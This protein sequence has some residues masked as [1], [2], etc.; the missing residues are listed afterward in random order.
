MLLASTEN[1]AAVDKAFE[2]LKKLIAEREV[3]S[4]WAYISGKLI[5]ESVIDLN[6]DTSIYNF[7]SVVLSYASDMIIGGDDAGAFDFMDDVITGLKKI[8]GDERPEGD[9]IDDFGGG[10]LKYAA[11]SRLIYKAVLREIHKLTR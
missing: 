4:E 7:V 2:M 3:M 1:P 10:Q 8:T 5:L 9:V 11:E 6:V